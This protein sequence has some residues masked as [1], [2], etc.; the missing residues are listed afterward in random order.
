MPFIPQLMYHPIAV[1]FYVLAFL[2]LVVTNVI[3]IVRY[4]KNKQF[5]RVAPILSCCVFTILIIIASINESNKPDTN[6]YLSEGSTRVYQ[7]FWLHEDREY[8]QRIRRHK[9][10]EET[11]SWQLDTDYTLPPG[12]K[13]W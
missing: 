4:F 5:F 13:K 6:H 9:Y 10:I 11:D 3:M 7:E 2:G 8:I 1:S 12:K